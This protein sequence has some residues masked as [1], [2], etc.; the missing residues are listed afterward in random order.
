MFSQNPDTYRVDLADVQNGLGNL[1]SKLHDYDRAEEYY[2][3]AQGNRSLLFL[4]N[5]DFY[6]AD[7][8]ITQYNL[9]LI[10]G[11]SERWELFDEMLEQALKNYEELA[12]QD[13]QYQEKVD[14]LRELKKLREE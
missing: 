7:L 10:Y 13:S 6:R 12:R 3:K 4:N 9:L 2:L 5:P 11:V 8:A 14:E 1:Y